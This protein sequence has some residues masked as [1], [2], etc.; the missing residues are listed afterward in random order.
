MIDASFRREV[1]NDGELRAVLE[2]PGVM[3]ICV[4]DRVFILRGHP[5]I[6]VFAKDHVEIRAS[7][8]ARINAADGARVIAHGRVHVSA[9][10]SAH[11]ELWDYSSVEAHGS[12]TVVAH[13]ESEVV[14]A[15]DV[16]VQAER[17]VR[18]TCHDRSAVEWIGPP[19]APNEGQVERPP[20][21]PAT[22]RDR[23]KI[24]PPSRRGL[25]LEERLAQ[26]RV[27]EALWWRDAQGWRAEALHGRYAFWWATRACWRGKA[28]VLP[29]EEPDYLGELRQRLNVAED[30]LE[31][32]RST[33]DAEAVQLAED[34][35]V[36]LREEIEYAST[37]SPNVRL[38]PHFSPPPPPVEPTHWDLV[39]LAAKALRYALLRH[40]SEFP[41][42]KTMRDG[43]RGRW[44]DHWRDLWG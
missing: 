10:D 23:Y 24:G 44:E 3:P 35:I 1:R 25:P 8:R 19:A 7:G 21:R 42:Y 16:R 38:V 28:R 37:T 34:D 39:R 5:Q 30:A 12:A 22:P 41:P 4:G 31:H 26:T 27:S 33:D 6:I 32:A 20:N 15:G 14:A 13:N 36:G 17:T 11:V 43:W 9:F 18:V 29:W 2:S 40:P